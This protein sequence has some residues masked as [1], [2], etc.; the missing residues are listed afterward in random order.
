MVIHY[1]KIASF[2]FWEIEH[3]KTRLKINIS[4]HLLYPLCLHRA[5]EH[6]ASAMKEMKKLDKAVELIERAGYGFRI[7]INLINL[8]YI[9]LVLSS[10][11]FYFILF[12][13]IPC[14]SIQIQPILFG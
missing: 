1:K 3:C 7:N 6:A 10:I 13:A 9:L 8:D 11:L 5:L 2:I 12:C 4:W 14:N